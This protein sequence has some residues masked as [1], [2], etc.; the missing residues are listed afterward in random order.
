MRWLR[1][2]RWILVSV[3]V[4]AVV[5]FGGAWWALHRSL[6]PIDGTVEGPGL[7][8]EAGIDRDARGIPVITARSSGKTS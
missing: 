2:L 1:W 8:A 3:V 6:P 7:V 5:A 4:L